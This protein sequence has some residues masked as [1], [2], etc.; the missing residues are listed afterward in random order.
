MKSRG[1]PKGP[2]RGE[3][4]ARRLLAITAVFVIGVASAD[5]RPI[6]W[7]DNDDFPIAE[8]AEDPEGEYIWW[9]GV[10]AGA[11]DQLAKILDLERS[12]HALGEFAGL[13]NPREA[14]NVNALDEVPDST[15]FTNRHGR[16]PLPAEALRRGANRGVPPAGE[17]PLTIV[18]GKS[19]GESPGFVVSDGNG[20]RYLVKFDPP[21][22]PD[23][24]TGAEMVSSRIVHT[25]GW[26]V[27]EYYLFL[28]DPKRLR[29]DSG[30]RVPDRYGRKQPMTR[31]ALDEILGRAAYRADGRIRAMASRFIPGEA[32]GPFR[33]VGTRSDDPND[34]VPHEDRRELRGFRIVAAWINHTDARRGNLYDTFVRSK[35]DPPGHGHLVHYLLDFS[36]TLG[37]GNIAW[38]EAFLGSE[39][40]FDPGKSLMRLVTFGAW[41]SPWQS[42]PLTHPALGY[43][44]SSSFD[45]E[46]WRT[47]YPTPLFAGATVRDSFWG[48][49]LV[50]SIRDDDLRAVVGAG[51][52]SDPEAEAILYR[53]LR[54]RR[55]KI[56]R[57]YFDVA[58]VNPVDRFE[59]VGEGEDSVLRFADLAVEAGVVP[60]DLARYRSR[61]PDG[62]WKPSRHP[63]IPLGSFDAEREI[64]LETSH[65]GGESWS[66]GTRVVVAPGERA[67][68]VIEIERR[69]R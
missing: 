38:K 53:V 40:Y 15:W 30:A 64:E 32:K 16:E 63:R 20:E 4:I 21:Q 22:I 57:A 58:R 34:T 61:S 41:K 51:E 46:S 62:E 23:M 25:L 18:S 68:E 6:L 1:S 29:I 33:T 31:A 17:G 59:V 8:P 45:P 50:H 67:L 12:L 56:A 26:N 36:N 60:A 39:Y 13:A 69:T 52:W 19:L 27:P 14:A 7:K 9:D 10:R 48:A 37:S 24:A 44:A 65:D 49:K 66:P 5:A 54:E 28:L 47:S 55:R 42:V 3:P 11:F 35:G 2:R 43:F